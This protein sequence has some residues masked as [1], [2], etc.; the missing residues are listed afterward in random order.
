MI[1][2]RIILDMLTT[3]SVSVLKQKVVIEG[4][5]EYPFGETWRRAYENTVDGI[6]ILKAEVQEPYLST[7]L[8]LWANKY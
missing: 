4:D 6:E 2:E 7:V 8:N 5:K 1:E 3:K